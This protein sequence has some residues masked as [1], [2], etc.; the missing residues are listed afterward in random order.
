ME[1][2]SFDNLLGM[3]PDQVP[4]R[5]AVDGLH[6][7]QAGTSAN[8]N[9][10]APAAG[11]RASHARIAVPAER[12]A[13]AR[14]GTPATR[15]TT[16]AATTA[17]SGPAAPIAMRFWDKCD[18]PFTYSLAQHFPIGERYFCSVLAPDLPEPALLLR[19]HGRRARSATDD[20]TLQ[21]PGRQRH[22]LR[23]ARR[24]PHQL[25]RS[26]TRTLAEPADR[27]G[28][29]DR[30]RR[31]ASSR[32]STSSTPTSRPASCRSSRSSTPTTA[33]PRR[34]T[35]RTSRSASSSSRSVVHALMHAPTWKQHGAVHHL[36]RARRLLRPRPAAAARSSPTRSRRCSRPATS[37][38][39]M[40]ATAS[41]SR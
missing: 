2:H 9:P 37:R 4:G 26:T 16:A 31:R 10:D 1:N 33:P 28:R 22:D 40:T 15:P 36:R 17:S 23:P 32:S 6:G 12:R 20:S 29:R 39:A 18:L 35:R 7:A 25:G 8:S 5:A 30:G 11:R 19:G 24:A 14:P 21:H 27:P 38:A 41:A 3:V 34:R 13:R